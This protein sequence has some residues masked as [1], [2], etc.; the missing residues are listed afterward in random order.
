MS[1]TELGRYSRSLTGFK[2]DYG[3]ERFA[4]NAF[5]AENRE[6]Y[7]RDELRGDGTS[8]PYQLSRGAIVAN[9]DRLRIEVR[10][11]IR[12]E[13]VVETR[14]LTR[15]I[16]YSLDYFTGTLLFKQPVASRDAAFNPV[17]IIAEYETLDDA[18]NGTTAG[19]RATT[20]LADDKLELGA[21]LIGEGS[22]LGDTTLTGTD[23]RFRPT[24][25]LEVRAEVARTASDN[26]LRPDAAGAYLA[27]VER[28]TERLDVQ[29]Y[30][31]EQEAGF[32]L[33][34]QQTSEVGTRK[35]GV[36]AR[37][38]ITE[39]WDARGEAFR[40]ENLQTGADRELVSAEARRE[41][42][43]TTA[44]LGLRSVTD[45]LPQ[46]G[47]QRSELMSVGGSLDVA[48]DRVTL[49][50]LTE[51]SLRDAAES[52]DFPERT[53]LGVDYHLTGATTLFA[54]V[55]DAEGEL[56]DSTMTRVGVRST[57][58]S[59]SQVNSSVNREFSE[60][61]PRVFANVGLTQAWK[62]GEAWAMDVGVDHSDTLAAANVERVNPNVPLVVGSLDEDFLATFIGAQY[63]ADLWTFT[64]R[65]ERRDADLA[66]RRSFIGGFFR[67]P[68]EGRALSVT[69][70]WLDNDAAIGAGRVVDARLSYAYRPRD[71][72]FIVLERLD[73]E[74]DERHE[75]LT[76]FE[77]SRFVNNVNLHWQFDN[78]FEFGTQL[79]ARYVKSTIDG[80]AYSGWSTLLG[81]DLRRDLTRVL[82]FGVH[83]TW[84]D[85]RSR[86]HDASTLSA[87]MSA[88][89]RRA[90]SGSRSA[91]TSRASAT[92]TSTRAATRPTAR[93][94]ASVSRSTRTRSRTSTSPACAPANASSRRAPHAVGARR[95]RARRSRP[96]RARRSSSRR[97][98]STR[99]RLRDR[100]PRRARGSR[101]SASEQARA[102]R[103]RSRARR[104]PRCCSSRIATSTRRGRAT[105][106]GRTAAR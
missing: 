38:E 14:V 36:D 76:R 58:W 100:R 92:S 86:R 19:A 106:W 17:Y 20:K 26:P 71:G 83:G 8:G 88:S 42:A 65:F 6:G 63:R 82:D 61:G 52:L 4:V 35:I 66:E 98:T 21:T 31:R 56:I 33:G 28:V 7:G 105:L 29:A 25:A 16:D 12:S 9:S 44:S 39:R 37:T 60:Y 91:T 72:K 49:R 78:R 64:S 69:T 2:A 34:Q 45:D 95:T 57:P 90:T 101:A 15:F 99:E 22:A 48:H 102:T 73:L 40:Q 89:R 47:T 13:V 104:A 85:S 59:G 1:V 18:A 94:C 77:T 79:G 74:Q 53:T 80:E 62:I 11:R 41:T 96:A 32:G 43:D 68:I 46:T 87:S 70:R 30:V 24:G 5:A 27:E 93:T 10:D 50:A 54:E 103:L 55:E 67:E 3:G 23:L 51:R 81:F 75:A 97:R 84:L